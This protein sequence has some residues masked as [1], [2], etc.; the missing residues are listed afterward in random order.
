M[1][2]N[3]SP[4]IPK[5]NAMFAPGQCITLKSIPIKVKLVKIPAV[6]YANP[7][8]SYDLVPKGWLYWCKCKRI[9]KEHNYFRIL[10][11]RKISQ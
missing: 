4:A 6:P 5:T 2:N 8:I 9:E 11:P 3:A 7:F 1:V 10:F